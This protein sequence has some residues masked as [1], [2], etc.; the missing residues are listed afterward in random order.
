MKTTISM[1]ELL[2]LKSQCEVISCEGLFGFNTDL[3]ISALGA[4]ARKAIEYTIGKDLDRIEGKK[5]QIFERHRIPFNGKPETEQA[6][7]EYNRAVTSDQEYK[8]LLEEEQD[9]WAKTMPD[10]I[11]TPIKVKVTDEL[12]GKVKE[13]TKS[14][15][16]RS[17]KTHVDVYGAILSLVDEEEGYFIIEE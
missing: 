2:V 7:R 14:I 10:F 13:R 6:N 5:K 12:S 15:T 17:M 9:L 16:W 11:V 8:D 4:R 3:K 1:S